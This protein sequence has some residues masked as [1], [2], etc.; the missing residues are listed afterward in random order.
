MKRQA[1]PR[2]T[3]G[4]AALAALTSTLL[5]AAG[6]QE[7][8][9]PVTAV[10]GGPAATP[11]PSPEGD[12]FESIDVN[13]VNVDVYVTDKKGNRIHGLKKEDFEL[14]EDKKLVAITNFYAVE[15]GRPEIAPQ[16]CAI[17]S[18]RHSSL[19]AEPNGVPSSK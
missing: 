15:E 7:P 9:P 2:K 8:Q 18:M 17:E 13:V 10:Q 19:R 14:Y 12:F 11:P 16:D 6:A 3:W 5:L 1:T 4:M